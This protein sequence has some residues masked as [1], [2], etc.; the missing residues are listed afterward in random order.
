M[1][2]FH[3]IC[4]VN[5]AADRSRVIIHLHQ[6]VPVAGPAIDDQR[7]LAAPLTG[8]LLVVFQTVCPGPQRVDVK[9]TDSFF[10]IHPFSTMIIHQG[11]ESFHSSFLEVSEHRLADPWL[12][13][14]AALSQTPRSACWL[15]SSTHLGTFG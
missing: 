9:G 2:P 1:H 10:S 12:R 6:P 8:K 15:D 14:Q 5:D 7:V 4:S 13:A 3:W 11:K